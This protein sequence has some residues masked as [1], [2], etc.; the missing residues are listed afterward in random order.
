VQAEL[1]DRSS[2]VSDVLDW[3]AEQARRASGFVEYARQTAG[4][5]TIRVLELTRA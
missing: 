5:R 2:N 1:V 3:N 4:V